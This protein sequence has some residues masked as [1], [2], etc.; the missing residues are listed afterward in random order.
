[1]YAGFQSAGIFFNGLVGAHGK[2]SKSLNDIFYWPDRSVRDIQ[3]LYQ[4]NVLVDGA[5][6]SSAA[7]PIVEGTAVTGRVDRCDFSD[8]VIAAVINGGLKY[9]QQ[10]AGMVLR[11]KGAATI[12]TPAKTVVI[13]H[14]LSYTPC[15]QDIRLQA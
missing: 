9:G 15:I 7:A 4:D 11:N 10:T 13:N 14:G 8:S 1:T 12:A 2:D 5:V 6:F 3:T